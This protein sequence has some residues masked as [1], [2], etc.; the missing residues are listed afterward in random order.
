MSVAAVLDRAK[1]STLCHQ[2]GADDVAFVEIGRDALSGYRESILRVLPWTQTFMVFACRVNRHAIRT[3]VRSLASAEFAEGV[4]DL[5]A[6]VHRVVRDLDADGI[7]AVGLTGLFPMEFERTDGPPFLVPLK[8]LAEASGLGLMGKN[9]MALHPR[10]GAYIYIGAIALDGTV[11][12][13]D[14]PL[15]HSPCI[16]CNL[17][18]VA[19]PTGAIAKDGHFDFTGCM[20]HNYRE[21]VGGFVEWVHTLADS[22]NRRDYRRRVSD[23]ETLSWWQSLAYDANTHCDYCIAVCPAGEEAASY[24]KDPTT[25]FNEVVQPLRERQEAIYVVPGSDAEAYVAA[26]FPHKSIRRIGSGRS[27]QSIAGMIRMLPLVFQRGRSQGL[28]ARYHFVFRGKETAQATVDIHDRQITVEA[29]LTGNADLTVKADS[30]AW[31]GFVNQERKLPW[32][33]LCGRI[34]VKGPHQLLQAFGRC[35]PA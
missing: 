21:K 10:F 5:K 13:Y 9:R 20:T 31:L 12:S 14:Q 29:G 1:L 2:A 33:M 35:F 6:I 23:V 26:S 8:Y 30:E 17:C 7:R 24:Q 27:P 28:N 34:R 32:E 15:E 18:A 3:T 19:C 25:H 11:D 22:R 4:R 16:D